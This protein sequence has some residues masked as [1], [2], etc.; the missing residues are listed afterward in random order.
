[1]RMAFNL[2]VIHHYDAKN[3][4]LVK[5]SSTSLISETRNAVAINTVVAAS[6]GMSTNP[7]N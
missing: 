4:G 1:M 5:R 2:K 7:S 3:V 6:V